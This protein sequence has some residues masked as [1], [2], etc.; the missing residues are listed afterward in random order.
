[1]PIQKVKGGYRWGSRGKV[2]PTKAQALLDRRK[3]TGKG[4][5]RRPRAIRGLKEREAILS[6]MEE[7][8]ALKKRRKKRNKVTYE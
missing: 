7:A 1:M 6:E 5:K 3:A 2:R 8:T 4:P